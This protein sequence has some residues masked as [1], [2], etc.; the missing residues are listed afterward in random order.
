MYNHVSSAHFSFIGQSPPFKSLEATA[1]EAAACRRR[2]TAVFKHMRS[3]SNARVC[4][5]CSLPRRDGKS[6]V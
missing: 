6:M 3:F 2:E 4:I 1:H 5:L